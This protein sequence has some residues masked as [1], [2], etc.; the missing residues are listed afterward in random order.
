MDKSKEEA[1]QIKLE[2]QKYKVRAQSVFNE[3]SNENFER[4][5]QMLQDK[6]AQLE[7]EYQQSLQA[8]EKAQLRIKTLE[9]NL[10]TSLQ[11]AMELEQEKRQLMTLADE[12]AELVNQVKAAERQ[13]KHTQAQ[14]QEGKIHSFL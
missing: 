7:R 8:T 3:K 9:E 14:H 2:F 12:N 11:H 5:I 1:T 4:K 6:N 10:Q 13:L